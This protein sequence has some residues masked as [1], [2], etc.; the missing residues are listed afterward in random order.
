MCQGQGKIEE[1]E[2][3]DKTTALTT[4]KLTWVD[5]YVVFLYNHRRKLVLLSW[6]LILVALYVGKDAFGSLQDGGFANPN[7]ESYMAT[8]SMGNSLLYPEYS[9]ILE[10]QGDKAGL[11]ADDSS[12]QSYY[13]AITASLETN[14][15]VVG[16]INYFSHTEQIKMVSDD[17]KSVLVF[18]TIAGDTTVA[19]IKESVQKLTPLSVDVGGGFVWGKEMSESILAGKDH[20]IS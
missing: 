16:V 12:F 7:S 13:N 17:R 10:V 19:K 3:L 18:A 15:P 11:T 6:I 5:K 2:Q 1:S 20:H 8:R 4:V 9:I 14:V